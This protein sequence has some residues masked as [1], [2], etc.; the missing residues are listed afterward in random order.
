MG[1][2]QTTIFQLGRQGDLLSLGD[3]QQI[4]MKYI[5]I[6]EQHV[7]VDC[8]TKSEEQ[9]ERHQ[10]KHAPSSRSQS[11]WSQSPSNARA[12]VQQPT[13]EALTSYTANTFLTRCPENQLTKGRFG[14][15]NPGTPNKYETK[16]YMYS[17]EHS[18]ASPYGSAIRP[19]Q[20]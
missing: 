17:M 2:G 1:E 6:T 7:P 4:A 5:P 18:M 19:T 15:S 20:K 9:E 3:G 14:F 10:S 8:D 12:R 16:Q 13:K 11:L